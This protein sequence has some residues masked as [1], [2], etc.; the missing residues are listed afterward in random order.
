MLPEVPVRV[1]TDPGE[2]AWHG[3]GEERPLTAGYNST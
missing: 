3:L 1:R 2:G